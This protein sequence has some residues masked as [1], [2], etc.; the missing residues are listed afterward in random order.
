MST[1]QTSAVVETLSAAATAAAASVGALA[2]EYLKLEADRSLVLHK[3]LSAVGESPVYETWEACRKAVLAR[4][5]QDRPAATDNAA[6]VFWSRFVDAARTY[7]AEND[8][9][10]NMPNK[11]KSTSEAATTKAA[12]RANPFVEK[13]VKEVEAARAEALKAAKEAA[14]AGNVDAAQEALKSAKM[15]QAAIDKAA[16]TAEAATL[17]AAKEA[18]KSKYVTIMESVK[19]LDDAGRAE[20]LAFIKKD[21]H[22]V[23]ACVPDTEVALRAARLRAAATAAGHTAK[24]AKASKPRANKAGEALM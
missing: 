8:Y 13:D 5:K 2:G 10:F 6:A 11:P 22:A 7:A 17:K 9:S 19:L 4:Y 24:P 1:V 15:A 16:K 23:L 21:W 18:E 3:F 14:L 20:V 12:Q